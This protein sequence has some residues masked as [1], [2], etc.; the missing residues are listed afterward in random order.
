MG[1]TS[2]LCPHVASV[3]ARPDP[4]GQE[5]D[6]AVGLFIDRPCLLPA[7]GAELFIECKNKSAG[8]V[9]VGE[10]ESDPRRLPNEKIG[11]NE[12]K[13]SLRVPFTFNTSYKNRLG[14]K[15]G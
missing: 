8:A 2:L 4:P 9:C 12:T 3:P 11:S 1:E 14:C 15:P 7:K 10:D 6:G 13:Q 5:P